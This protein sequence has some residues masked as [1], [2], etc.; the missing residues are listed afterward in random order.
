MRKLRAAD[1]FCG[2]GGTTAGAESSGAVQVQ[3]ALNHWQT[4]VDTHFANFPHAKHVNS[5]LEQTSPSECDKIDLLF[6]S[7]ECTHHSRARGGRPTS[8]QQRSGAWHVLPWIEHHRPSYVVIENV[9]EF[10]EWGPVGDDGRPLKSFV[11]KFFESWVSSIKSAGYQVD[12]QILNAADFGAA[13]SRSRMFLIARKGNRQP[14]WPDAT[15]AKT[16][17]RSL[18]GGPLN[19]WRPA[20]DIIDWSLPC[21]SIFSRKRPLADKTLLRIE[22]GLRRFVEPFIVNHGSSSVSD[23][24]SYGLDSTMGSITTKNG[25]AFVVPNFGEAPRQS[26]RCHDL[27][28]ALPTITSHGAGAVAMPFIS[29]QFG[30]HGGVYN[31]NVDLN[32]PIGTVT[33]K[34]HNALVIPWIPHYYGTDNQSPINEPLDTITT[35]HRHSL[36]QAVMFGPHNWPEPTSDAMRKLQATMRELTVCDIGFR[37]LQ[38]G[39]LSAAQGFES[40][41]VFKG[42]KAD[43]TR[44]IGNSV[45][46]PVAKSICL[47]IAG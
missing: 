44:Q 11:G 34:D 35:K 15:H 39:E 37:M 1:L 19:A 17:L 5:R 47:S 33:T 14:T 40:G 24:R 27:D 4:A 23:D 38:N 36:C 31:P 41:Y 32:K 22:A 8:D 18:F 46:P 7:P 45:S 9:S 12:H 26:P 2:A 20:F 43:V 25:R 3:F 10:R 42:S 29:K 16:P 30:T 21:P 13:T 28:T 6:A